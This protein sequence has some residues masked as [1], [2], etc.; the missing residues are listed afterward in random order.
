MG[1]VAIFHKARFV[2]W[3]AELFI[4][5]RLI[6]GTAGSQA[7]SVTALFRVLTRPVDKNRSLVHNVAVISVS[8]LISRSWE[9]TEKDSAK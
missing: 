6:R 9:A 7:V 4:C 2:P 1:Q 3:L 8:F 5:R